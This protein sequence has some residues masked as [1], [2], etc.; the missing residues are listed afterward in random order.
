M[1]TEMPNS[2]FSSKD[3][4]IDRN[5]VKK[6]LVLEDSRFRVEWF[7]KNL[8]PYIESIEYTDNALHCI[9]LLSMNKYDLVMLDHDLEN[10]AYVDVE[11]K[12]T[13]STVAKYIASEDNLLN[14][15]TTVIIHSLNTV[16]ANNM[17]SFVKTAEHIP[18]GGFEFK[19][20]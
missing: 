19:F 1:I 3:I 15:D 18:F 14:K 17:I 9:S 2:W 16:G 20:K 5:V 13:G 10:N 6:I 11:E 12:N 8:A 7:N 4:T